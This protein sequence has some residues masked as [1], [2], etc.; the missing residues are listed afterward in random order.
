MWRMRV[1]PGKAPSVLIAVVSGAML[2][3][4]DGLITAEEFERK[5][6][7]IVSERW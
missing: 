4:F 1:R 3:Y 7:E 6:G 5:R 2:L